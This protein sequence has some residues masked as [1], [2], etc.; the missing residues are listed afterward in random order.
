M[1]EELKA[2]MAAGRQAAKAAKDATKA[3]APKA[4]PQQ[5]PQPSVDMPDLTTPQALDAIA[6]LVDERMKGM[7]ARL[8]AFEDSKTGTSGTSGDDLVKAVARLMQGKTDERGL[9]DSNYVPMGKVLESPIMYFC[10]QRT[11]NIWFRRSGNQKI[12]PPHG[13]DRIPFKMLKAWTDRSQPLGKQQ[14]FIS[15]FECWDEEVRDWLDACP[16]FGFMFFKDAQQAMSRGE[17][18]DVWERF[19]KNFGGLD[20]SFNELVRKAPEYGIP[21]SISWSRDDYRKAIAEEMTKRELVS[22]RNRI[23]GAIQKRG[24]ENLLTAQLQG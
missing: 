18:V 4:V 3:K 17:G 12:M 20:I 13:M 5:S 21:T 10:P 11:W 1:S 14:K 2:K 15:T 23:Q 19:S 8:R 9:T 7:E 22:E 24:A 6:K 16:E